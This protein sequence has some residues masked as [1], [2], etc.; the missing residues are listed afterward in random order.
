M[1]PAHPRAGD[2][3]WQRVGLGVVRAITS[4]QWALILLTLLLGVAVTGAVVPRRATSTIPAADAAADSRNSVEEHQTLIQGI[5][6]DPSRSR[7]VRV[8]LAAV[9]VTATLRLLS[10]WVPGWAVPPRELDALRDENQAPQDS[11]GHVSAPLLTLEGDIL[12]AWRRVGRASALVGLD[13]KPLGDGDEGVRLGMAQRTGL[14]RWLPG[15]FYL[16]IILLL[17]AGIVRHHFGVTSPRWSLTLGETRPLPGDP[18]LALHLDQVAIAPAQGTFESLLTL[19]RDG[20]DGDGPVA[21]NLG[22]ITLG[23]TKPN[24]VAGQ[25]L[26]QIGYGPAARVTAQA[27]DGRRL[28]IYHLVGA[29]PPTETFRVAF[30]G[31]QSEELLA[32]PEADLVLRLVYYASLPTQDL[33]ETVHLQILKGQSR[34]LLAEAFMTGPDQLRASDVLI[35]VAPEYY[36]VLQLQ[37]EPEAPLA[38]A[39]GLMAFLGMVALVLWPP[40][41]LWVGIEEHE[42]DHTVCQLLTTHPREQEWLVC[43]LALLQEEARA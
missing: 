43:I 17:L 15:L 14:T 29:V 24:R 1:P 41:Y 5:V 4:A 16:G 32:I 30:E 9:G 36:V 19:L 34:A 35:T 2:A 10:L 21:A 31:R 25:R 22:Q 12:S 23:P 11:N 28:R 38:I 39:G 6:V 7:A 18:S 3:L 37:R 42:Q 20:D 40:R 26:Y 33:G 8:L 13:L 27:A